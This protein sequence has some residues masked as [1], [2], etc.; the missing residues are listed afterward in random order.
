MRIL[1]SRKLGP[2]LT[3]LVNMKRCPFTLLF[4]I[5]HL[6]PIPGVFVPFRVPRRCYGSRIYFQVSRTYMLSRVSRDGAELT[7]RDRRGCFHALTDHRRARGV[8]A[9]QLAPGAVGRAHLDVERGGL[10]G[11]REGGRMATAVTRWAEVE[12]HSG[13]MPGSTLMIPRY[14]AQVH[15]CLD[16]C[17]HGGAVQL[18]SAF[19]T[20]KQRKGT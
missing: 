7:N 12:R 19:I 1:S 15:P 3:M 13:M 16:A 6:V 2:G 11:V 14:R 8:R 17:V 10:P 4:K 5:D 9:A 18:A 20:I